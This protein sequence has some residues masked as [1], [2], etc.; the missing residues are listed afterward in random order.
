MR[1][2]SLLGKPLHLATLRANC[3]L[4]MS[5]ECNEHFYQIIGANRSRLPNLR[6][7]V[8]RNRALAHDGL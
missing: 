5:A 4:N 6:Y 7:T 8:L 1:A 3:D 2:A